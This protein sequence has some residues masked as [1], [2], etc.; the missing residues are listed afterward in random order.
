MNSSPK[1]GNL[2]E[3]QTLVAFDTETT[4]LWAASHRIV[5]I[6]AVKFR[7]DS[8]Q[9]EDFNTLVNPER[10]IGADVIKIHGIT[11]KMVAQAPTIDTALEQFKTFCQDSILVAHNAP[12]DIS[13][14]GCERGRVGMKFGDNPILDT[15]DL[16]QRY[17]PGL[18]SYALLSLVKQMNLGTSQ[19][20]RA[21]A[22]AQ[23]V[24]RLT[25]L[26][27]PQLGAA[28]SPAD[29]SRI[30]TV[31]SMNDWQPDEV[32]LPARFEP[33][34]TAIADK[35]RVKMHYRT[36]PHPPSWRVI[37]PLNLYGVASRIYLTAFC[38]TTRDERTFRVDR[39]IAIEEIDQ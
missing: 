27:A 31:Y 3:D 37:K 5:E 32:A 23:Y 19:D 15:I 8:G 21:L 24:R 9:L 11:N 18:G 22:D 16:Y 38:E 4:G 30:A 39:I 35:S 29:L 17:R 12:F 36:P 28:G 25:Q 10:T 7:L 2:W 34:R 6:G 14:V 33:L 26:L 1:P 20:H 13:F